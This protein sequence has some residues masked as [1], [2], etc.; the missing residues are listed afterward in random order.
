[1]SPFGRQVRRWR[2]IR[3]MSQLDLAV[4]A[5]TTSRHLSFVETGRSRPGRD[6]ILR[7]ADALTVPLAERN[8]LLAAAGLP[9]AF[10]VHQLGS[11]ALEPVDRVLDKV[12][13]GHEPYP[14][15]VIR[16]PLTIVRA[17]TGAEVLFPGLA[18]LTPDQLIDLWY[19]PGPFRDHVVN[20]P[21]VVEAGLAA[22]R[23]TVADTGD[24]E[25]IRLLGRAEAN[26]RDRP[27][28]PGLPAGSWPVVCPVF[29][30]GGQ[31][32]RTISTVMRFDTAIEITTSQ[33]RIELMFPADA[34]A[35]ASFRSHRPA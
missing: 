16:Q 4:A 18:Q 27:A 13:A 22:L 32:V 24:P 28:G 14:A 15:W 30:L 2:A 35:E 8:T 5:G 9:P 7:I 29:D 12:L 19:G 23:H 17:N 10:P 3:R 25:V 31:V 11:H 26:L 6:L 1:V 34:A 20:W 21:D 33:L